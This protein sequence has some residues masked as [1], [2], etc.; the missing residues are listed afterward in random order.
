MSA[1][2]VTVA[3]TFE[4]NEDDGG[5]V[6]EA[7]DAGEVEGITPMFVEREHGAY[8][9][10]GAVAFLPKT[11][12]GYVYFS[13][14]AKTTTARPRWCCLEEQ[15]QDTVD[16]TREGGLWVVSVQPMVAGITPCPCGTCKPGEMIPDVYGTMNARIAGDDDGGEKTMLCEDSSFSNEVGHCIPCGGT[17]DVGVGNG[18]DLT[19]GGSREIFYVDAKTGDALWHVTYDTEFADKIKIDF[20]VNSRTE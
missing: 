15:L 19:P 14:G 10:S 9:G 20:G 1:C 18:P 11:T 5:M 6:E 17:I 4:T 7:R 12:G 8:I 3:T 2:P 16:V 13:T